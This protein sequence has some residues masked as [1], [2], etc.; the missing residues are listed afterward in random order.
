MIPPAEERRIAFLSFTDRGASLAE[1]LR[2]RLGGTAE[3]ARRL[4]DFS[5]T[6]WTAAAFARADALVFIGAV[7]IAVRAV[8]PYLRSKALDPAVVAVDERARF[9][10]PV[11]SGHLGGA[12]DLAREIARLTG[13]QAVVTTA[14]DAGGVFAVDEWA[15]RQGCAVVNPPKIKTVSSALLAGRQVR[16]RSDFPVEGRPPAGV[17]LCADQPWDACVSIFRGGEGLRLAPRAAV[18]GVGC[19][20]GTPA[21]ALERAFAELTERTGLEPLAVCAAATIDLKADEPGLLAFCRSRGW[22]LRTYSAEELSRA[23]G[24]FSASAFVQS[25]TGVDNVCERSAV[26]A[27]GGGTLIQKKIAGG[28]V[29]MALAVRPVRL[30]W[31]WQDE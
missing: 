26:L 31:R 10:V 24:E 17:T 18:L 22:P 1:S 6:E 16:I 25:V 14:T 9:A 28:G 21:E 11:A 19:R 15:R 4:P 13:A 7:G 8:A 29:T 27:C 30:N 2:E 20:R 12:N 3:C 23:E 5:L